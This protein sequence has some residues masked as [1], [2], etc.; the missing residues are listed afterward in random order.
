M[1]GETI[2]ALSSAQGC[3]AVNIIRLSGNDAHRIASS[4][5]GIEIPKKGFLARDVLLTVGGIRI[6]ARLFS[7]CKP[8]SYTTED[9]VE[10]HIYGSRLLATMLVEVLIRAGARAALP[11]EFTQ[12]AFEYGRIGLAQAE[13]VN[14]LVRAQDETQRKESI[15]LLVGEVQKKFEKIKADLIELVGL[16]EVGLD[17][18]DQDV[19]VLDKEEFLIRIRSVIRLMKEMLP[20][21]VVHSSLPRVVISGRVNVGKSSLFNALL[22]KARAVTDERP[23]TT[24]DFVEERMVVGDTPFILVDTAGEGVSDEIGVLAQ[25]KRALVLDSA[26]VI[27]NVFDVEQTREDGF[28]PIEDERTIPVMNKIDKGVPSW[29]KDASSGVILVSALRGDGIDKLK[30]EICKRL[31]YAGGEGDAFFVLRRREIV[32]S[33]LSALCEAYRKM[34]RGC[35]DELVA[36]HLRVALDEFSALFESNVTEEILYGIFRRFCIGK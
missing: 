3:C 10:F 31:R 11:G 13:A 25:N 27:L 34:R 24:R 5:T 6:K 23:G 12:R 26:A 7:F 1:V 8:Y 9:M 20:K 33:A 15:A 21:A 2:V 14:A 32:T 16:A 4:L 35:A 22:G 17:F 36:F 28:K 29:C 30:K 18:S 19:E